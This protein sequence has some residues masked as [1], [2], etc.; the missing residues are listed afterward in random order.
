MDEEAI[1]K[2]EED[3]HRVLE[4]AFARATSRFNAAG[5]RVRVDPLARVGGNHDGL[6]VPFCRSI[7]GDAVTEAGLPHLAS[8][9]SG[10]A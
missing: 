7:R 2:L 4:D 1:R 8:A 10:A 5:L 9:F 6:G 3:L